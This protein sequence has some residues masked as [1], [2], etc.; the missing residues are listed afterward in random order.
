MEN[1]FCQADSIFEDGKE[2][3]SLQSPFLQVFN[4]L[5]NSIKGKSR[6]TFLSFMKIKNTMNTH[7]DQ[8][9]V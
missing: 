3:G 1:G 8:S 9:Q 5:S 4:K 2:N 6:Q 7:L